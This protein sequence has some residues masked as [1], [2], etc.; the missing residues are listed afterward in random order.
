MTTH[1]RLRLG[2]VAL[3]LLV[4]V[5]LSGAHL[6]GVA[7]DAGSRPLSTGGL[8]CT[9][10]WLNRYQTL[11]GALVAIGAAIVAYNGVKLQIA[12]AEKQ[13]RISNRQSSISLLEIMNERSGDVRAMHREVVGTLNRLTGA[14]VTM[15]RAIMSIQKM[16]DLADDPQELRNEYAERFEI[17]MKSHRAYTTAAEANIAQATSFLSKALISTATKLKIEDFILLARHSH[18]T[19]VIAEQIFSE[20]IHIFDENK[21]GKRAFMIDAALAEA[22][23]VVN[24]PISNKHEG[25]LAAGNAARN[26]S[27]IIDFALMDAE[28]RAN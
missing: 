22:R 12:S 8:A 4:V 2:A 14:D 13:V 26:M 19:H 1:T 16:L 3:V 11:I 17:I 23:S 28:G 7:Q 27:E 6:C 15:K 25:Y 9:E 18:A 20:V 21:E 10:F 5:L 24:I